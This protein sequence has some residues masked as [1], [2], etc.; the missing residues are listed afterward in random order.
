MANTRFSTTAKPK[1]PPSG[2]S[3]LPQIL[4]YPQLLSFDDTPNIKDIFCYVIRHYGKVGLSVLIYRQPKNDQVVV[5][6][7]DWEGNKIDVVSDDPSELTKLAN[8]FVTKEVITFYELMRLIKIDQAQFFFA[9]VDGELVLVDVQVSMNKMVSPGM[10]GD[11]FSKV[12]P[13]Q[14]VLA[15]EIIDERVVE[16]IQ[17]GRGTYEGDLILKPSRFRLYESDRHY[18]PLYVEIAR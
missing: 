2:T 8:N 1:T 13:T 5:I 9:V 4:Q 3:D 17:K 6:C 11:I 10:I 15:M 18:Q 16:F 14:H 7:G 12:C